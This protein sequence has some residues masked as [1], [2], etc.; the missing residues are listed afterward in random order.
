MQPHQQRVVQEK[1]DL[2]VKLKRLNEFLNTE[3]FT[4]LGE[5]ERGR[6]LR[7]SGIMADYSAVL[8]Q[9]IEAF[10][11][12]DGPAAFNLAR[13]EAEQKAFEAGRA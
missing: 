11:P 7:Q 13:D 2:D 12:P 1:N 9:R 8:T 3:T 6:L 4:Q 10:G 5:Q